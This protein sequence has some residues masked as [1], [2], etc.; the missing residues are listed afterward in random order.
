MARA[1]EEIETIVRAG[2]V[3]GRHEIR[4]APVVEPE[5]W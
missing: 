1:G 5:R 4:S 2:G 3:A